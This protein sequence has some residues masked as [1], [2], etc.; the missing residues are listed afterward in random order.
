M[1]NT[2]I[3]LKTSIEI[4]RM[5]RAARL[6]EQVLFEAKKTIKPGATTQSL[7]DFC[8]A[9]IEQYGAKPALL[10]YE[11]FPKSASISVN[12][13]AAHGIPGEYALEE[14]DIVCIDIGVVFDGWYADGAWTYM[15]GRVSADA[16]RLVRAAWSATASGIRV[17]QAG[18]RIGDIGYAIQETVAR[19][20]CSVIEDFVGHGIGK[21][22]HEDPIIPPFGKR[23][24]GTPIVPGMVFTIE[25]V[26]CLGKPDIGMLTDGWTMVTKDGSM[27]AQYEHTIAVFSRKTEVLTLTKNSTSTALDFPPYF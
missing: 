26:V 20:G 10:G 8:K 23:G 21:E 1:I 14:G 25:P 7:N 12:S 4:A 5:R 27:T 18:G 2:D 15:C 19:F 13:I 24:T 3:R 17:A 16:I 22:M 9:R 11:G 6:V